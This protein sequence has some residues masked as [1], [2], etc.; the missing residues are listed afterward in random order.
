VLHTNRVG[1]ED[2]VT[3]IGASEAYGPS[4]ERLARAKDLDPDLVIV[5]ADPAE[6]RAARIRMPFLREERPH[7]ILREL[8]RALAE[9]SSAGY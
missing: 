2:G 3:F 9:R 7:L 4:G 5:D 1:V 8:Q 6:R